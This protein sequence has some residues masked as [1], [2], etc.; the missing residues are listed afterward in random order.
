MSSVLVDRL[1][2][3]RRAK[4]CL[5]HSCSPRPRGRGYN[6]D[7]LA[8]R[9]RRDVA[10]A[11]RLGRAGDDRVESPLERDD[12]GDVDVMSVPLLWVV[13]LALYLITFIVAFSP[14]RK[15]QRRVVSLTTTIGIAVCLVLVIAP[16]IFPLWLAL[17]RHSS[18]C[19]R[20]R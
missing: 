5:D 12:A 10:A 14:A 17:L 19:M 9:V 1:R 8:G 2:R 7:G 15:P 18:R 3:V 20:E 16:T 11:R 4:S 6:V 13:P